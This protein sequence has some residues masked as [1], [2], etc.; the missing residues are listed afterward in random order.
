MMVNVGLIGPKRGINGYGL[1]QFV[2]REILNAPN[3]DLKAV[4]GT[5]EE[6]VDQAVNLINSETNIKRKFT[7]AKYTLDQKQE[8]F[9][10][11]DIAV[12]MICSPSETHEEYILES[13][14]N[15]KHV[16]V[17]KP[18]IKAAESAK[19]STRIKPARRLF[20]IAERKKLLLS[21]NCQR[22]AVIS[23]LKEQFGMAD[24]VSKLHIE[25]TVGV[26]ENK[27]VNPE[28]LFD[29]LIAHPLS[30][31]VKLGLSDYETVQLQ[32][33]HVLKNSEKVRLDIKGLCRAGERDIVFLISLEQLVKPASAIM[34]VSVDDI[35]PVIITMELSDQGSVVT[36]YQTS[37]PCSIPFYTEDIL[38]TSIQRMI[39]AVERSKEYYQP[40]ITNNESFIIYAMQETLRDELIATGIT[41]CCSPQPVFKGDL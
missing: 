33:H 23:V 24:P 15:N 17:D 22:A 3:G 31:M 35:G 34:Q 19:S 11:N 7:G 4:M 29:L 40:L 13:L 16:L 37:N 27:L 41:T 21:T 32:G 26:K 12:V 30:L 39:D 1:G 38:Q 25:L 6:S 10:R 28:N 5:T 20:D 2:A 36:R 18:L 8:F 9:R 14:N